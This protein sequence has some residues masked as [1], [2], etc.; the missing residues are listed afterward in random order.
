MWIITQNNKTIANKKVP[1]KGTKKNTPTLSIAQKR[2]VLKREME[3]RKMITK[4]TLVELRKKK[5]EYWKIH[6]PN[7]DLPRPM[8][9]S[10]HFNFDN[11]NGGDDLIRDYFYDIEVSN[12]WQK[13][14][15]LENGYL[16]VN[17][18]YYD[19]I[20]YGTILHYYWYEDNPEK[21]SYDVYLFSWY[22]HRGHTDIAM[23]NGHIMS[24]DEYIKLLNLLEKTGYIF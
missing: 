9:I 18:N 24:E 6:Y 23:C 10:G 22:K 12:E 7:S 5:I 17:F 15:E 1:A 14:Y 16:I 8:F 3:G 2:A 19:D 13:G 4:E 20:A 21:E 11:W